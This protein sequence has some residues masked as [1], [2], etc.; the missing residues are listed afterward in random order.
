[1]SHASA[2]NKQPVARQPDAY[3]VYDPEWGGFP[4]EG[5]LRYLVYCEGD[6]KLHMGRDSARKGKLH[7]C[8]RRTSAK[9]SKLFGCRDEPLPVR[10]ARDLIRAGGGG[11]LLTDE[12][13]LLFD[14]TMDP[15]AMRSVLSYLPMMDPGVTRVL[16]CLPACVFQ[17]VAAYSLDEELSRPICLFYFN[18]RLPIHL[19][20]A[21]EL[22]RSRARVFGLYEAPD[23]W[24]TDQIRREVARFEV[25][26][27]GKGMETKRRRRYP[28]SEVVCFGRGRELILGEND[29]ALYR[30]V[31]KGVEFSAR[32]LIVPS[33]GAPIIL[34]M[35]GL[36]WSGR[37]EGA[38]CS[39]SPSLVVCLRLLC[40]L[41]LGLA[42]KH[43][44]RMRVVL[45]RSESDLK[46]LKEKTADIILVESDGYLKGRHAHES[47]VRFAANNAFGRIVLDTAHEYIAS[48]HRRKKIEAL[49]EASD[50]AYVLSAR[51]FELGWKHIAAVLGCV[52]LTM[53]TQFGER[54]AW[55][56]AS[57]LPAHEQAQIR[58]FLCEALVRKANGNAPQSRPVV[59]YIRSELTGLEQLER[60][61][62]KSI[63]EFGSRFSKIGSWIRERTRENPNVRIVVY[64]TADPSGC[65]MD[66]DVLQ[67]MLGGDN[68]EFRVSVRSKKFQ[69]GFWGLPAQGVAAGRKRAR[70]EPAN[71][72]FVTATESALG[73]CLQKCDYLLVFGR[74]PEREWIGSVSRFVHDSMRPGFSR[75]IRF[76]TSAAASAHRHAVFAPQT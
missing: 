58:R 65:G 57:P 52:R 25:A 74:D 66:T 41:W 13:T 54:S 59:T 70:G 11:L 56:T 4:L 73:I 6:G 10:S 64:E 29:L 48:G 69:G 76:F 34:E 8:S 31:R 33:A 43:F 28:E 38:V 1:M 9:Y 16:S 5:D 2:E 18:Q 35:L 37:R 17:L 30:N 22:V 49:V 50:F 23:S 3:L 44:P 42:A 67:K 68:I 7:C 46:D 72:L 14:H 32:G 26:G 12:R 36:V 51:P 75:V 39:S 21:R 19:D 53:R 40:D 71:V 55:W 62:D 15:R 20:L 24:S 63:M 27:G 47:L 60:G 61:L 45:V